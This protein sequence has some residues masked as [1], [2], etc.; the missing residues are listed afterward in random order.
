MQTYEQMVEKCAV[1]ATALMH[2]MANGGQFDPLY[3]YAKPSTETADGE[4]FLVR[5]SAPN[6]YGYQLVCPEALRCNI[7]YSEYFNWIWKR[8]RS[9]PIMCWGK[10]A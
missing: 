5:D 7:P 6:P 9:A 10:Q 3:L 2:Q 4:L 8:A 1:Q